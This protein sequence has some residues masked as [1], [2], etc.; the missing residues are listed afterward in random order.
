[1]HLVAAIGLLG[2]LHYFIYLTGLLWGLGMALLS[3]NRLLRRAAV[4]PPAA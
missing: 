4:D 2:D 3:F 1:L